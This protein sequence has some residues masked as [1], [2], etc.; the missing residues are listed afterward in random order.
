MYV[1]A[2]AR[3]FEAAN[4]MEAVV[5]TGIVIRDGF[6]PVTVSR[7]FWPVQ[8]RPQKLVVVSIA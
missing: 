7:N 3:L 1:P 8:V 4:T 6:G 5:A 2:S